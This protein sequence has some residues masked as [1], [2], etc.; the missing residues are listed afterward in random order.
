MNPKT[1]SQLKKPNAAAYPRLL[2]EDILLIT[3]SGFD[4]IKKQF[5][6]KIMA[7]SG[8]ESDEMEIVNGVAIIDINGPI[9]RNLDWWD[10]M[11]GAVDVKDIA[12]QIEEAENS[13]DVQAVLFNIDSPGG[14]VQGTP[15]LSDI[16]LG[17][18]KPTVS[19]TEGVMASAAYWIGCSADEV[20][21]TKSA[22]IGSIGVYLPVYDISEML[23]ASGVKLQLFAS[24]KYKGM[25]LPGSTLTKDQAKL[26]QSR[27]M[28]TAE[29]F[30]EHVQLMRGTIQPDAMQGQVFRADMALEEGL[31]DRVV[32]GIEAAVEM[33]STS[34][35]R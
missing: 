10:R 11:F 16:I 34:R 7:D 30:W 26:L 29:M 28:E 19:Y 18:D 24:G 12:L 17:M 5:E 21:A 14:M 9:G 31:I 6:S 1:D 20:V 8:F 13:N 27:V 4:R 25:G 32:S 3:S 22:D 33:A 23:K 15:E 35:S 2:S